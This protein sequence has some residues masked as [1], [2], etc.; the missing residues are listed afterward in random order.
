MY[1]HPALDKSIWYVE[2]DGLRI[3]LAHPR[4]PRLQS[5]NYDLLLASAL[6]G[7]GVLHTP[8]WSAAPYLADGRLVQLMSDYVIDPDAFGPQI[9][10]VYPSHR[11]AT[12]GPPARCWPLSTFSRPFSN[13]KASPDGRLGQ[14]RRAQGSLSAGEARG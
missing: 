3:S 2:R 9:L 5:D 11:R 10:A 8:L 1:Q 6:A 7:C 14:W 13:G 4:D 12:G